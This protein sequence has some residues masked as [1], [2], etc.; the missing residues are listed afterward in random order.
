MKT[1]QDYTDLEKANLTEEEVEKLLKYELME[2]GVVAPQKPEL[3]PEDEPEFEERIYYR[4]SLKS[5]SGLDCVF[6]TAKEAEQFMNLK[7]LIF[8]TEYP[9][10]RNTFA[11]PEEI[12]VEAVK[13][14]SKSDY[15]SSKG[16]IE[17][18]ASNKT[19]NKEAAEKYEEALQSVSAAT[20]HIWTEWAECR[21]KKSEAERL[22]GI[23]DQYVEDCDGDEK[24]ALKFLRKAFSDSE[25]KD[26]YGF[27]GNACPIIDVE[28][29]CDTEEVAI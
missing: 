7:P 3:L 10:Y 12:R 20:N 4:P 18:A 16:L 21:N 9:S 1:F 22:T 17:G 19:K 25:I 15:E 13:V 2:L 6:E 5:Y 11:D 23:Y 27:L 14:I 28:E 29:A 26:A 24:I 8:S